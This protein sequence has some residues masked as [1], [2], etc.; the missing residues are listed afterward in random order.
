MKPTEK[1]VF[2]DNIK[3]VLEVGMNLGRNVILWGP[4]G[5]G[6]IMPF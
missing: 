2:M 3:S 5:H 1:F 4:G 6:M